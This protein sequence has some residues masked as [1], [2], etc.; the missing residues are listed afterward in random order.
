[1]F[2]VSEWTARV[3]SV[4]A[5]VGCVLLIYAFVSKF[6][7]AWEALWSGLILVTSV[8]LFLLARIVIVDMSLTFFI[9]LSLCCFYWASHMADA[10]QRRLLYLAMYAGMGAGTLVKGLVGV[11]L[12]G[13][14][15]VAFLLLTRQWSK[16]RKMD[17]VVGTILFFVI[18][19]PWC[20]LVEVR[21]PGYLRYFLWEEHFVRFFSPHFHRGQPRY[22]FLIVLAVGFLP[23]TFLLPPHRAEP[24]EEPTL[25]LLLQALLISCLVVGAIRPALLPRDIGEH[26]SAM[27]RLLFAMGD[28][29]FYNCFRFDPGPPAWLFAEAGFPVRLLLSRFD[30]SSR[31][32]RSHYGGGVRISLRQGNRHEVCCFHRPFRST[33]PLRR[34]PRRASFLFGCS[35]TALAR[36]VGEK[37]L[38]DGELLSSRE[39]APPG[40]TV[41]KDPFH[42]R[43]I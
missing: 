17:L 19:V 4:V 2:G 31:F 38:S 10:S 32:G 16:L 36:M 39:N 26:F 25:F 22:Y 34:R 43:R 35:K 7:G 28:R 40:Q 21:N 9:T 13:M 6:C 8:E 14:I 11:V 42:V 27:A 29:C 30:S 23:W 3:P 18:V 15:I 5:T 24:M 20:V 33:G 41:W 1:M 37:K 12:P